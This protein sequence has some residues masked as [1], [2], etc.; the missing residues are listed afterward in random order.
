MFGLTGGIASGKSTAARIFTDLGAAVI[1]TDKIVRELVVPGTKGNALLVEAFGSRILRENGFVNRAV[2]ASIVFNDP[3]AMRTLT[4]IMDPLERALVRAKAYALP[5]NQ[6]CIY[7]SA[8][9]VEARRQAEFKGLVV[10][11]VSPEV[12]LQRLMARNGFTEDQAMNRIR[13]QMTNE[14]KIRH[15]TWAICNDGSEED[16]RTQCESVYREMVLT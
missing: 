7:E 3:S 8:L 4:G 14:E 16:L 12:Q 10:V 6:V 1:D 5:T 2:L 9:I 11:Y 13:H 15:A